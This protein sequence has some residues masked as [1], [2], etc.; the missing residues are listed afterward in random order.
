MPR[1]SAIAPSIRASNLFSPGAG[2]SP[3]AS[4]L[5]KRR[6][7]GTVRPQVSE[8]YTSLRSRLAY[9]FESA[10]RAARLFCAWRTLPLTFARFATLTSH[11]AHPFSTTGPIRLVSA[12][13]QS[14]SDILSV[15]SQWACAQALATCS[16]GA[17]GRDARDCGV[18]ADR[19]CCNAQY[20][21][22]AVRCSGVLAAQCRQ[23]GRSK[24][25]QTAGRRRERRL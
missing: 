6:R 7:G 17:R 10:A 1:R 25:G 22:G 16:G 13:P 23:T 19:V 9:V 21:V 18:Y 15:V 2:L 24:A 20:V 3:V 8:L 11:A 5:R 4:A 12:P 14:A